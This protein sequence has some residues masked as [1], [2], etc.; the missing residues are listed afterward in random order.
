MESVNSLKFGTDSYQNCGGL[1]FIKKMIELIQD[2]SVIRV[3]NKFT[4]ELALE[5]RSIRNCKFKLASL[6]PHFSKLTLNSSADVNYASAPDPHI[7]VANYQASS[8]NF[9]NQ[10]SYRILSS[11]NEFKAPSR[12]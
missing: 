7:P 3:A 11:S 4:E 10:N 8:I 12:L 1:V 2:M 5:V 6:D 9:T